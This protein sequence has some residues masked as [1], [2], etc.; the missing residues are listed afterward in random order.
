MNLARVEEKDAGA[1]ID[2]PMA[3]KTFTITTVLVTT[4]NVWEDLETTNICLQNPPYTMYVESFEK[5]SGNAMFEGFAVDMAHALSE[6]LGF[7][8]TIKLVDDGKVST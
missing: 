1:G 8:Y 6:Q 4:T 3:N 5:L 2:H 7:N